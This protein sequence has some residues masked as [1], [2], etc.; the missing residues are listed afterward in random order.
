MVVRWDKINPRLQVKIVVHGDKERRQFIHWNR[1]EGRGN[2]DLCRLVVN[3]GVETGI[4][5]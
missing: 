5:W 3:L 1:K 2:G 4:L